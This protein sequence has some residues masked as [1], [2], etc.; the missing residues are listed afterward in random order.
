MLRVSRRRFKGHYVPVAQVAVVDLEGEFHWIGGQFY[1]LFASVEHLQNAVKEDLNSGLSFELG[2]DD[3]LFVVVEQRGQRLRLQQERHVYLD[4]GA[5]VAVHDPVRLPL[6]VCFAV[7]YFRIQDRALL[8][9]A[10]IET[11]TAWS[12]MLHVPM[13]TLFRDFAEDNVSVTLRCL[14]NQRSLRADH[15]SFDLEG[16]FRRFLLVENDVHVCV[17]LVLIWFI[18]C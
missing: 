16:C 6:K 15:D 12:G 5:L 13:V 17:T 3:Q 10:W 8:R 7:C 4:V 1:L 9:G 11:S 2:H 14:A 18:M